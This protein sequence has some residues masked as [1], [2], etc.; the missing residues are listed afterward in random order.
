MRQ[1]VCVVDCKPYVRRRPPVRYELEQHFYVALRMAT[2]F[3][4]FSDTR[5]CFGVKRRCRLCNANRKDGDICRSRCRLIPNMRLVAEPLLSQRGLAIAGRTDKHDYSRCRLIEEA[6]QSRTLND[7][8]AS[9]DVSLRAPLI[10]TGSCLRLHQAC[11]RTLPPFPLDLDRQKETSSA[12]DRERPQARCRQP[13]LPERPE[14]RLFESGS[15]PVSS[16]YARGICR[17]RATPSFCL[18]TSQCAFAV[19]GEMPSRSPTSSLE[20]PAAINS[21]TCFCRGVRMGG[22]ACSIVDMAPTLTTASSA[23]Y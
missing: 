7:V 5:G 13:P 6:R 23:G 3:D 9:R 17:R 19:L 20:Q 11:A 12:R 14:A 15:S 2:R 10:G 22:L 8:V 18:R 1:K 21:T 16:R 4:A